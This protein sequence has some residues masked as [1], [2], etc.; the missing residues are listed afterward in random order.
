[1]YRRKETPILNGFKNIV[2]NGVFAQY[3]QI[4]HFPQCFLQSS[5]TEALL[6]GFA[7]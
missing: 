1:M 4:L 2:G 5:A 6:K 3:E 7:L